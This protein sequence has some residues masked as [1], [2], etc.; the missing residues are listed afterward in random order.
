MHLA[1][2]KFNTV[3]VIQSH[4]TS[5]LQ[6]AFMVTC[7]SSCLKKEKIEVQKGEHCRVPYS[8][9]SSGGARSTVEEGM[10]LHLVQPPREHDGTQ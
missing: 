10:L 8:K 7:V 9:G 5:D 6:R 3:N 4:G 2:F 1:F